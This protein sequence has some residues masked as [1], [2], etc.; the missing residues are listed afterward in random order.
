MDELQMIGAALAEEPSERSAAAGRD[1]LVREIHRPARR[2][3]RLTWP[4][5]GLGAVVAVVAAVAVLPG[6]TAPQGPAG[7]APTARTVLLSVASKAERAPAAK[8]RYWSVVRQERMLVTAGGHAFDTFK[9][10]GLWDAGPGRE[11]WIAHR[12]LGRRDLG[13]APAGGP[14]VVGPRGAPARGDAGPTEWTRT[15]VKGGEAYRLADW[16]GITA[17]DVRRLPAEPAA[18]KRFLDDALERTTKANGPGFRIEPGEWLFGNIQKIGT[19]PVPPRVLGAA[20]RM[21]AADPGLRVIG[22]VTD[23]L[24]RRGTAIARPTPG[25]DTEERLVIDAS[26]GRLLALE[27][28]L[29]KPG[30][31]W[32]GFKAGDRVSY[33]AVVSY[34]WTDTVPEYRPAETG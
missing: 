20:Y 32:K 6:G 1:R 26:S 29:I 9:Q 28:V 10:I 25:A 17:P 23:P 5:T 12:D 16:E 4:L 34:G 31:D 7:P 19:A 15:R 3:R 27:T 22:P 13:P 21:L 18:L 24:G 8:G 2:V 33:D 11:A 14:V 30:P